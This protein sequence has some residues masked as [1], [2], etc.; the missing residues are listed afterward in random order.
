MPK[1]IYIIFH[2]PFFSFLAYVQVKLLTSENGLN[3]FQTTMEM[4]TNSESI[5]AI[6][7]DFFGG[8][9]QNGYTVGFSYEDEKLLTSAHTG[10]EIKDEYASLIIDNDNSAYTTF[11]KN[12]INLQSML[13]GESFTI[14]CYNRPVDNYETDPVIFTKEWGE[15]TL[16]N[17]PYLPQTELVVENGMVKD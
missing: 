15:T 5:A 16:G 1:N 6:N 9:Y 7:G 10:N 2:P 14:K 11:V 12:E 4:A 17:T 3:T 13:T 8:N